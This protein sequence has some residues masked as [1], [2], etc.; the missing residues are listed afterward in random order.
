[1]FNAD[2]ALLL[3]AD[4]WELLRPCDL[5]RLFETHYDHREQLMGHLLKNR[6]DLKRRADGELAILADEMDSFNLANDPPP[7]KPARFENAEP[8][9]QRVLVEGMDLCA[10]QLDL[11]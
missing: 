3:V 8:Q 11:F 2:N 7:Y 1:M 4:S 6:P 10:G 5:G 9:R